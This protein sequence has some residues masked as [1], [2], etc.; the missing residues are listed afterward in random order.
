MSKSFFGLV[1]G[2]GLT[3]LA[4]QPAGALEG[5]DADTVQVMVI[6]V[7]HM[8]NPGQDIANA[9]IEDV[10]TEQRQ[11]EIAAVVKS[12]ADFNPTAIAVERVTE[13]PVYADPVFATFEK[14]DLK[15]NRDE[16][17]QIAYRLASMAG[18]ERV[19]GIDEIADGDEPNY[20]PFDVL[21]AHAQNTGQGA[22]LEAAIG[23][24]QQMLAH[25]SDA[26]KDRSIAD[27]LLVSNTGELADPSFYYQ[28][29]E[30]DR[31]ETQPGAELQAYWF[32]RN[33]KIF[34]KLVQVAEPGDRIVV[35]YGAGHKFWLDHF[36]EQTPGFVS[37]DPAPYLEKAA[38]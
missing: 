24:A 31:G 35:V 5:A 30:Y 3:A 26:Q 32:M 14:G 17:Y 34:S 6:G 20:F 1:A 9:D 33:A 21:M 37:V 27:M 10:L 13:P 38:E 7:F 19:Y 25:F 18:V 11:K 36:A 8:D 15:K 29:F 28:M 2:I 12:V 16:R 23:A 4:V 22:S